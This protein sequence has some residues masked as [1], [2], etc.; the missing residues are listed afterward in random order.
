MGDKCV[1]SKQFVGG[2]GANAPSPKNKPCKLLGL[3]RKLLLQITLVT[4]TS[5]D[6]KLSG[7]AGGSGSPFRRLILTDP[8]KL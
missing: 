8:V 3:F 7:S 5:K 4:M 6:C 1:V 2:G